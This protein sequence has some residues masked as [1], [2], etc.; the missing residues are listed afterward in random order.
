MMLPAPQ[1]K[2]LESK[3]RFD[4]FMIKKAF[5]HSLRSFTGLLIFLAAAAGA[6]GE[7]PVTTSQEI[8]TAIRPFPPEAQG[9]VDS[10]LAFALSPCTNFS[11]DTVKPL[12]DFVRQACLT[13]SGW[14]LPQLN[15]AAGSAYIMK[16][17]VPLSQYLALNF[18]PG[19]PDYAVFPVALRFSA[20]L[21]S[22]DMQRA[23]A[24]I[25][26]GPTGTLQY[27]TDRITGMEEITPNPESGCYFSYTNSRVFLRCKV[28]TRDVLFS[29]AETLAPSSF[30]NRGI[31]VGPLDQ[32]L[33]YY[34]EKPGLNVPGMT[35]MLSQISH[36]TTL[37]I[38]IALNSNETAVATFA[39]L[40]AGW[41]GMNVTRTTHILNS[42]KNALDCSRRIAQHPKVSAPRLAAIVDDVNTMPPTAIDVEY[43]KYLAYITMWRD[44]PKSDFCNTS[45]LK[46]LYD[47]KAAEAIPL[48]HQRALL[49]QERIRVLMD[50]P[51]WSSRPDSGS[52]VSRK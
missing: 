13:D 12:V 52:L 27:V 21:N 25:G 16:V 48:S 47:P 50:R 4:K 10:M 19:I 8:I 5:I 36:S 37:S 22:N 24:C 33:F 14:E 39:W 1:Q 20:C 17:R 31:L 29:C 7:E 51:T 32:A 35:W 40:N 26:A 23:Y 34:S 42:Q 9:S 44:N 46:K 38:Y 6:S 43:G 2:P 15:G 30:S 3:V 11:P 18:H 41:K 45:L 49:V 28:D